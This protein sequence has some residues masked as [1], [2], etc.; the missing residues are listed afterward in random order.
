MDKGNNK[1]IEQLFRETDA[2][3]YTNALKVQIAELKEQFSILEETS[4][5][6]AQ[7]VDKAKKIIRRIDNQ[8]RAIV[9]CTTEHKK[10]E[11]VEI[12]EEEDL[13][14]LMNAEEQ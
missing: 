7:A 6:Q 12:L 14:D 3:T 9:R 10:V 4:E 13:L 2:L 11:L 8:Y 1:T 5:Y